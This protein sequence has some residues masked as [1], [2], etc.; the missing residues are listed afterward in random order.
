MKNIFISGGGNA[1]VSKKFDQ[2][3]HNILQEKKRILYIPRAFYPERYPSCLERIDKVFPKSLG[4]TVDILDENV[5]FHTNELLH[6]YDGIYI[7]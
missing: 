3:Y 4:Y 7:G 6:T 5:P 1:E 2:L